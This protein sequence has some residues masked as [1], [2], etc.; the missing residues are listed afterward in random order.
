MKTLLIISFVVVLSAVSYGQTAACPAG[1]V[2]ISEAAANAALRASDE[3]DAYK[4]ETETLKT[5]VI[6][7][8]Q[9]EIA[10]LQTEIA[11]QVGEKTGAQEMVVRLSALLDLALKNTRKKCMPLSVCF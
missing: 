3:R 7:E 2:C 9:K 4:K 6:P 5:Q 11:K 10:T 8:L 1:F